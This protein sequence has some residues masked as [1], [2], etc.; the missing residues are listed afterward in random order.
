M[1]RESDISRILPN[2]RQ[3]RLQRSRLCHNQIDEQQQSTQ[4]RLGAQ[5]TRSQSSTTLRRCRGHFCFRYNTSCMTGFACLGRAVCHVPALKPSL[6]N[7][8][9]PS[10]CSSA[11][12]F[13]FYMAAM[14]IDYP[15]IEEGTKPRHRF[16]S[17]YEQR[18]EAQD[19]KYQFLL[20]AADPYE[21]IAFKIP[22]SEVDRS[23]R[24]FSYW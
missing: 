15:E 16:M 13:T 18:K 2:V 9:H 17:A 23:D 8:F 24:L 14:Q 1:Y 6:S 10:C 22:N 11:Q 4:S 12:I 7:A 20:F 3:G 21:V 5:D 19:K